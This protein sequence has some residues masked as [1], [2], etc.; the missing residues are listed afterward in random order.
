MADISYKYLPVSVFDVQKLG[1]E[2]IRKKQD[3]NKTSSRSSLAHFLRMSQNGV[4]NIF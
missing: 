4:R 1:R 3:H 2:T